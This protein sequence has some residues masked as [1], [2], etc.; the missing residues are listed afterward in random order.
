MEKV[1][2]G[3]DGARSAV[4]PTEVALSTSDAV[5]QMN[6]LLWQKI[7]CGKHPASRRRPRQLTRSTKINPILEAPARQGRRFLKAHRHSVQQELARLGVL[8]GRG[9]T[10]RTTRFRGPRGAVR[11]PARRTASSTRGS[12]DDDLGESDPSDA[13]GS[14]QAERLTHAGLCGRDARTV[15]RHARRRRGSLM[16]PRV[17]LADAVSTIR[18]GL[19]AERGEQHAR[20]ARTSSEGGSR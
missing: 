5:T 1:A 11:P 2:P 17:C 4:A 6:A 15:D 3:S 10:L 18:R 20:T 9:V 7:S 16:P 13:A 19:P 14:L 8:K 12:P